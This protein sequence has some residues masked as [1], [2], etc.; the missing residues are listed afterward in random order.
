MRAVPLTLTGIYRD[1]L[2]LSVGAPF[3]ADY[4]HDMYHRR[5]PNA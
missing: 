2:T 3:T 5:N 1:K 4:D